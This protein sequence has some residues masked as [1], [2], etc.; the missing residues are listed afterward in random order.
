MRIS[1]WSSGVCS[2]DLEHDRLPLLHVQRG[3]AAD[4]IFVAQQVQREHLVETLDAGKLLRGLEQRVQNMET[5]LVGGKP[6]ALV[7]HAAKRTHLHIAGR[8][9][10]H[11]SELQSLMRISY[12]VF[13]LKKKKLNTT[14]IIPPKLTYN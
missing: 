12:A 6:G 8:S 14:I 9:E 10:E 13:C 1:E 11:T 3:N 4:C 5:A 2:S 7:L